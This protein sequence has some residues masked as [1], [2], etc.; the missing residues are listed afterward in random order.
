MDRS[1]GLSVRGVKGVADKK[2]EK[3]TPATREWQRGCKGLK[4][5]GTGDHYLEQ[6]EKRK[7]GL[8]GTCQ[9]GEQK[10]YEGS[11]NKKS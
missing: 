10:K 2:E 6:R 8:K 7:Q 4:W 5:L 3:G 11:E 9:A 1:C